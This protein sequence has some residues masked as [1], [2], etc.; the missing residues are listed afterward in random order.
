MLEIEF[1]HGNGFKEQSIGA[2]AGWQSSLNVEFCYFLEVELK[3]NPSW[4][5]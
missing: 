5:K 3:Q 1:L 2:G 4:A